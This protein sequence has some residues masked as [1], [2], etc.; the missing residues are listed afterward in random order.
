V[1][2]VSCGNQPFVAACIGGAMQRDDYRDAIEAAVQRM[3]AK[4]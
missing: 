2:P 1:G 3:L 4:A